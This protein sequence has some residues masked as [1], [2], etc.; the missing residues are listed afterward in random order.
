M[1]T[2]RRTEVREARAGEERRST[3]LRKSINTP[4]HREHGGSTLLCSVRHG[5]NND[6]ERRI[7]NMIWTVALQDTGARVKAGQDAG[8]CLGDTENEG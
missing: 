7:L 4:V 8:I 6:E 3:S 5:T 2:E 1:E